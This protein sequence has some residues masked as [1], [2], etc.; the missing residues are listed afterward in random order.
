M[1]LEKGFKHG[2]YYAQMK[3]FWAVLNPNFQSSSYVTKEADVGVLV[4]SVF[5]L[6]TVS[7][8]LLS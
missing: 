3:G 5:R 8:W 1:F 4:T 7:G 6:S 2:K